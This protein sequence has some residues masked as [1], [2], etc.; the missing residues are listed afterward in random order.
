MIAALKGSGHVVAMI[1]DGIND[2]LALKDAD[3]GIAMGS[4]TAAYGETARRTRRGRN[5]GETQNRDERGVRD[6]GRSEPG[7]S[8]GGRMVSV[9][10][11][12][13]NY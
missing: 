5:Q 8:R 6:L 13:L 3:L 2:V 4:R 1:G 9:T 11:S 10:R 12:A 7:P